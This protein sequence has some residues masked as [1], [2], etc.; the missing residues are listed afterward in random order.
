[1]D[2]NNRKMKN[3][4]PSPVDRLVIEPGSSS[5]RGNRLAFAAT[6]GNKKIN[7]YNNQ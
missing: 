6:H 3:H 4:P 2:L 1:M 7:G 5:T